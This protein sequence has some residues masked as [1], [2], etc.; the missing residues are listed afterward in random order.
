MA[1]FR[2]K[3]GEK[4]YGPYDAEPLLA[5]YKTGKLPSDFLIEEVGVDRILT[6]DEFVK[7]A[8]AP[9]GPKPIPKRRSMAALNARPLQRKPNWVFLLGCVCMMVCFFPPWFSTDL[10]SVKGFQIPFHVPRLVVLFDNL[11]YLTL[12]SNSLWALAFIGVFAFYSL[13]DELAG[14]RKTRN[15]WWLRL[16]TSLFPILA[17][18]FIFASFAWALSH[19]LDTN[20]ER[21]APAKS[22]EET[23]P[24]SEAESGGW[25]G[26]IAILLGFSGWGLWLLWAGMLCTFIGVFTQPRMPEKAKTAPPLA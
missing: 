5:R 25:F 4:W 2:V 11:G 8:T 15:R 3:E 10:F 19:Y 17:C 1:Q 14:L 13:G 26:L 6:V 23:S 20:P 21:L 16:L 24:P 7:L 22:V 12:A 18:L 9:K